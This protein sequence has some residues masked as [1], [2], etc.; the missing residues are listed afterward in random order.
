ML[1]LSAG[2]AITIGK[3]TGN[4]WPTPKNGNAAARAIFAGVQADAIYQAAAVAAM[5]IV[6]AQAAADFGPLLMA[7]PSD[8]H[9]AASSRSGDGTATRTGREHIVGGYMGMP[10]NMPSDVKMQRPDGTDLTL[11]DVRW[12]AEPFNFPIFAGVRYTSW[13]GVFGGMID[14][15]HNKAIAHVGKG[16]HGRKLTGAD[17]IPDTVK[18]EGMLKGAPAATEYK[19]TDI[20]ERLEFS[21]GHN[22]LL[23]TLLVRLANINP[24]FRPYA[25]V[26]AG[27]AIPHVEI[28][29]PGEGQ[30]AKTNEYQIAGPAAQGILGIE[31]PLKNGPVFL[32]YKYTWASLSTNMTGGKTP[33]W[34]NCD[35]VSDFV[36]NSLRWWRGDQPAYG[37]LQTT[38]ITHQV[39]AGAGYRLP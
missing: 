10:K 13:H 6:L 22:M 11:K 19:I 21:H 9:T 17:A 27:V 18:V 8:G 31:I 3:R 4:G 25:G 5:L 34:C 2:R 38:L 32:E 26:G 39:V 28:F 7:T 16:A 37:R 20:L 15:M 1:H 23:P 30:D 35:F 12:R 24:W 36:R 33:S 14:F 29:P